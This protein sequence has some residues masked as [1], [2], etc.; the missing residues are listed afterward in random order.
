MS[1]IKFGSSGTRGVNK[2]FRSNYR[3]PAEQKLIQALTTESIRINGDDL[4]YIPRERVAFDKLFGEDKLSAFRKAMPLEMYF[5]TIEKFEG[6]NEI[7]TQFGFEIR[8]E[9]RL[10]VSKE[11]FIQEATLADVFPLNPRPGDLVYI[12]MDESIFEVTFV[13]DKPTFYQAGSLYA[14]E[15]TCKRFEYGSETFE[16]GLAEVDTF[17][18][19]FAATTEL[20]FDSSVGTFMFG[21]I[22]YQGLNVVDATASGEVVSWD[23]ATKTLSVIKVRGKF[24]ESVT[25]VG[26]DSGATGTFNSIPNDVTENANDYNTDNDLTKDLTDPIVNRT[27]SNPSLQ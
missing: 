17:Q 16:T 12:P 9:I 3:G 13:E 23:E 5:N 1:D 19:R 21:E 7:I 10:L 27:E 24:N 26:N 6:S 14:Y 22:A 4:L 25:V 11:R 8:D 18:S 2:Y 15:M 20:K